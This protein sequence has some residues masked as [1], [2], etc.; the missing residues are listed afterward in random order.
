[1]FKCYFKI[2]KIKSFLK[3]GSRKS[4]ITSLRVLIA[5][6]TA[7]P[8]RAPLAA[9][10]F[11]LFSRCTSASRGGTI[12]PFHV[13]LFFLFLEPRVPQK[14]RHECLFRRHEARLVPPAEVRS[15]LFFFD[16]FF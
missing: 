10:P 11:F 13:F 1:M 12:V 8:P 4:K 2:S 15:C 7:F 16:F 14:R 3:L 9:F 5:T 6:S